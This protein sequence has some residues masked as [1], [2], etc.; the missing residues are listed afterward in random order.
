VI[1]DIPNGG[2]VRNIGDLVL[3]AGLLKRFCG[4]KN[5]LIAVERQRSFK[6][7]QGKVEVCFGC[8]CALV[9]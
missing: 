1:G 3:G 6:T 7:K 9:K 5:S 2:V 8:A 4:L